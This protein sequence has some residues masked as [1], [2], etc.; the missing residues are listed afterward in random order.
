MCYID[1]VHNG[2]VKSRENELWCKNQLGQNYVRN[3]V[4]VLLLSCRNFSSLFDRIIMIN[5]THFANMMKVDWH[6]YLN[7]YG[8]LIEFM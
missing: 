8:I 6:Q 5:I 7:K 4:K 2:S 1:K 3:C